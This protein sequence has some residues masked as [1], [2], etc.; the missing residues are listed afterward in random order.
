MKHNQEAQTANFLE[1]LVTKIVKI[2][3]TRNQILRLE[4]TKLDFGSG[5]V[6]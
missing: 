6:P 5:F 4:C 2:L 1:L 3:A